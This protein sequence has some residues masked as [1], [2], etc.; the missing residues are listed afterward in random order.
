MCSGAALHARLGRVVYGAAEPRTGAAGSVLNVFGVAQINH[1][2]QVQGGVLAHECAQVMSAFFKSRRTNPEPLRPDAL[3]TP[4][5]AQAQW[6]D[7]PGTLHHAH[8]WPELAGLRLSWQEVGPP[9]ATAAQIWVHGP[10]GSALCWAQ[11]LAQAQALGQRAIAVDL[12][13]FG[14]SDKPKKTAWHTPQAH[15]QVLHRLCAHL[16][17]NHATW[18]APAQ[19]HPLLHALH[20]LAP[21]LHT[22]GPSP[23]PHSAAHPLS[24]Q[25]FTDTGH[26]AGPK[27]V[28]A[29]GQV[30]V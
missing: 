28:R 17:L 19:M 6:P 5:A 7:L 18:L 3:R 9:Q 12:L 25:A 1:H 15:A 30:A 4:R 27:A 29:W 20:A 10:D 8:D 16:Q 14:R 11:A 23:S 21:T 26:M 24:A 2:T 22:L 13:G